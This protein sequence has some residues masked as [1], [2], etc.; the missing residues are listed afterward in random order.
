MVLEISWGSL[1]KTQAGKG[2]GKA[3]QVA[4]ETNPCNSIQRTLNKNTN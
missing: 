3:E 4:K 1:L 2:V